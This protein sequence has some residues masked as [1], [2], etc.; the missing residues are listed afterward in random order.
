MVGVSSIISD[1]NFIKDKILNDT[2]TKLIGD[3][4]GTRLTGNEEQWQKTLMALNEYLISS[5]AIQFDDVQMRNVLKQYYDE[6]I[7]ERCYET[8]YSLK[9]YKFV[10]CCTTLFVEFI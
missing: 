5:Q 3:E 2:T 4:N 9:E 6:D 1:I 7:I 8:I 10:L